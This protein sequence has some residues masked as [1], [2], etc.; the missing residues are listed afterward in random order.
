VYFLFLWSNRLFDENFEILIVV[1]MKVHVFW[2][3]FFVVD[4]TILDVSEDCGAF[5]LRVR[6]CKPKDSYRETGISIRVNSHV[7]LVIV[8]LAV[9]HSCQLVVASPYVQRK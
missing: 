3:Y 1:M 2:V 7:M 5:I 9:T 6:K 8:K 4:V